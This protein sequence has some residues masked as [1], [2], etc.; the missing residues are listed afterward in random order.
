M[1]RMPTSCT[2]GTAAPT[3]RPAPGHLPT[4]RPALGEGSGPFAV[5]VAQGGAPPV[6]HTGSDSVTPRLR[7]M[8]KPIPSSPRPGPPRR[9][10]GGTVIASVAGVFAADTRRCVLEGLRKVEAQ[11]LAERLRGVVVR[12]AGAGAPVLGIVHA[13]ML[14]PCLRRRRWETLTTSAGTSSWG[15]PGSRG[16]LLGEAPGVSH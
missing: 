3:A 5:I 14:P 2:F 1:P 12:I 13:G 16:K 7:P 11:L 6:L 15:R 4:R 10:E 9:F 8:G